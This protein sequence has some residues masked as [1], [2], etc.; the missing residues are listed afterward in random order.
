MASSK[1]DSLRRSSVIVADSGDVTAIATYAPEDCTTNPSLILKAATSLAQAELARAAIRAAAA[2]GGMSP[3]AERAVDHLTVAIGRELAAIVPGKV[4]SEVPA[5]LSF[6]VAASVA[7][8][9][10]LI[11]LYEANGVSRER[12]LIKLAGTWEGIRTAEILEAR[13]IRCNVTLI[14]SLVQAV[15][16]AKAGAFLVSPFVGRILDWHVKA[17][18][19]P[20]APEEDPGVLSVRA[21]WTYFKHFELATVVMGASFRSIG[22]VEA[23][24]GCDRLTVAPALLDVLAREEG[25]VPRR[26]VVAEAAAAPLSPVAVDEAAFRWALNG[27]AMATEKLA[28]GIRLFHADTAKL[29]AHLTEIAAHM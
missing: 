20:F 8:A 5:R 10:R 12:I 25:E 13:G 1:L 22:E 6:D 11:A 19:H 4:S 21:I 17:S 7:A 27:D 23:L 28:E 18:G 3:L 2:E 24:A 26:L 14:F 16:A 15:A 29:V 9:E